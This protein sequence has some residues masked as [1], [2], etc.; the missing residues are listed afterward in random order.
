MEKTI[1]IVVDYDPHI[2]IIWSD[3]KLPNWAKIIMK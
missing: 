3:K 1:E 2:E